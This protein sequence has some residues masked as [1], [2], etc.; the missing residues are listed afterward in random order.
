MCGRF[1]LA[2]DAQALMQNFPGLLE[3]VPEEYQ[4]RYNIA[5]TQEVLV[6]RSGKQNAQFL[7]WGLV[8][9]FWKQPKLPP[10]SFNARDD[11]L[12]ES[13][14]W[15]TSFHRK[16]C[17]IPADGFYEWRKDGKVR[18]P[19]RIVLKNHKPFAFAGLWDEWTNP[20]TKDKM[21]SCTIIT[22]APNSLMAAIHDRM[23]VI[24]PPSDYAPWL[25]PANDNP[26]TL[27]EF[28]GPYPPEEMD[29]YQVSDAV[30]NV[31]NTGPELIEPVE[32]P[33]T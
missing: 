9:F 12:L 2:I 31:R 19:M 16:R 10:A 11:K 33:L 30:G 27:M 6:L 28:I 32:A 7:R 21:R 13:G 3:R 14:M 29:A 25:D 18:I 5:P 15:R 20:E 24:L 26:Q 4:P 1:T 8:P 22:T 23:P 17:L